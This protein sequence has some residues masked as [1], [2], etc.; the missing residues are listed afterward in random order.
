MMVPLAVVAS[1]LG[2][3]GGPVSLQYSVDGGARGGRGGGGG[4]GAVGGAVGGGH[5]RGGGVAT[6]ES[7]SGGGGGE[8]D[9]LSNVVG[10]FFALL[11]LPRPRLIIP[12]IDT[13]EHDANERVA[14]E[15]CGA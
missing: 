15:L 11:E 1:G 3:H 9:T 5:F 2:P 8:I 7:G 6:D 10:S 14:K 4:G 12:S 13:N